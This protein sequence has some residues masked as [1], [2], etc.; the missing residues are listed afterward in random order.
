MPHVMANP[1][2]TPSLLPDASDVV[3]MPNGVP[4]SVATSVHNFF[5]QHPNGFHATN[6]A[7]TRLPLGYM[8]PHNA[9]PHYEPMDEALLPHLTTLS[10]ERIGVLHPHAPE[11]GHHFPVGSHYGPL[12]GSSLGPYYRPHGYHHYGHHHY[13]PR[14]YGPH[15]Y[16]PHHYGPHH[17]G[18]HHYG[19]H[20]YGP[21]V[22][23]NF[24]P[25]APPH[26]GLHVGPNVVPVVTMDPHDNGAYQVPGT[27]VVVPHAVM[28]DEGL[29]PSVNVIG[30]NAP[31]TVFL[32]GTPSNALGE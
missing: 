28:E 8:R 4:S 16:G 29:D 17:Y 32:G 7:G 26:Y 3:L 22:G 20:H 21:H 27:G 13:G 9:G 6:L 30:D 25:R 15:H 12:Y 1:P 5:R 19:L 23:P 10:G 24:G 31:G 11:V 18:P 14:H 2:I